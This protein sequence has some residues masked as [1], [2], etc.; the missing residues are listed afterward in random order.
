MNCDYK[1]WLVIR[2]VMLSEE[3][4]S[5]KTLDEYRKIHVAEVH[6]SNTWLRYANYAVT[7]RRN[8][9]DRHE[10]QESSYLCREKQGHQRWQ[11][12]S[13]ALTGW[14]IYRSEFCWFFVLQIFINVLLH[15]F[16][17]LKS[18]YLLNGDFLGLKTEFPTPVAVLSLVHY[19]L[20]R[21]LFSILCIAEQLITHTY[22]PI[23][24]IVW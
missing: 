11:Q 12:C 6:M 24:V 20:G 1:Q 16:S 19:V 8:R 3:S 5:H 14:W 4:K 18:N 13:A 15:L 9:N 21:W 2:N 23:M 10:S 7:L 22:T 17:I